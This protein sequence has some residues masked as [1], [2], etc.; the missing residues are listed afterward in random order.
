VDLLRRLVV[1]GVLTGVVVVPARAYGAAGALERSFG[2]DGKA[3]TDVLHGA[4][5]SAYAV[6]QQPNGKLVVAGF[7][8]TQSGKRFLVLR[9]RVDG[10]LD[11][12]FG[13]DGRVLTSF[14]GSFQQ[15]RDVAVTDAGIVVAGTANVGG[16]TA[17]ALARY[18]ADGSLDP[19]FGSGGRVLAHATSESM[20]SANALAL[21]PGGDLLV[22]GSTLSPTATPSDF[23]VARFDSA[24]TI[25]TAFGSGGFA[26]VDFS[27]RSDRAAGIA[28]TPGGDVVLAGASE[29]DR[30]SDFALAEV[31]T[32]SGAPVPDFGSNGSVRTPFGGGTPMAAEALDVAVLGN[33]KIVACG[34]AFQGPMIREHD[35]ALARYLPD[36]SPDGSFGSGGRRILDVGMPGGDDIATSLAVQPNGKM[37]TAGTTSIKVWMN[38]HRIAVTRYRTDGSLDTSFGVHGTTTT[39]FGNG[40]DLARD[41]LITGSGSIVVVG[42]AGAPRGGDVAV[43]L[44]KAS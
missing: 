21:V 17:F 43:V 14:G 6:A 36:G 13:S 27:G 20:D 10:K 35:A 16:R 29:V 3:V 31:D 15:A 28:R 30:D 5:D 8:E 23:A 25:D 26:T 32:A 24:G 34:S 44:Y 42:E 19:A 12:T 4:F 38:D 39:D 40:W 9:Y 41:L 18:L 11:K 7:A 33:G 37:V 2:D 22:A 1:V